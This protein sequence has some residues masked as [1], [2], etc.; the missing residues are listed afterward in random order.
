[1]IGIDGIQCIGGVDGVGCGGML[2]FVE[3]GH[4]VPNRFDAYIGVHGIGGP[5]CIRM[6]IGGVHGIGTRI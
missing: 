6:Y 5:D 4:F 3:S 2:D 1:M